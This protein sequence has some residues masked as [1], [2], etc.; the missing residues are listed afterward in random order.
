MYQFIFFS[1]FLSLKLSTH[2]IKSDRRILLI[3]RYLF[4]YNSVLFI[5]PICDRYLSGLERTGK[6]TRFTS[7]TK[8]GK[9]GRSQRF[10]F[11]SCFCLF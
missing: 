1:P 3:L 6:I 4:L 10:A 11:S 9:G 8:E 5:L 7:F 2:I